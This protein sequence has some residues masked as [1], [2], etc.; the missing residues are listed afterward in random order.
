MQI[1]ALVGEDGTVLDERRQ[2]VAPLWERHL[3]RPFP[4]R[5]RGEEIE[6]VDM[7]LLDADIA[8]CTQTWLKSSTDLDTMRRGALR[9]CLGDLDT[10]LPQ[11]S[12]PEEAAY[13]AGLRELAVGVLSAQR[14]HP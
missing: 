11:L 12:D 6:G 3:A 10:V 13:Y 2:L 1:R 8:G 7:V 5:L 9:D 4:P 14:A